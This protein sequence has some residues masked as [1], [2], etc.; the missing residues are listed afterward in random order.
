MNS[1]LPISESGCQPMSLH[2]VRMSPQYHDASLDHDAAPAHVSPATARPRLMS[3]ASRAGPAH[4]APHWPAAAPRQPRQQRSPAPRLD[5]HQHGG[6]EPGDRGWRSGGCRG[7]PGGRGGAPWP[8]PPRPRRCSPPLLL[9]CTN[10]FWAVLVCR[11][12]VSAG[13]GVFLTSW[14]RPSK[15][16]SL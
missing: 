7:R 4:R 10:R 11:G 16:R 12:L 15:Q 8:P 1:A 2:S 6:W 9:T 13:G 3:A 5:R 14:V